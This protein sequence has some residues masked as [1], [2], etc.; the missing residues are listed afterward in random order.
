VEAKIIALVN[1]KRRIGK[2]TVS[3]NLAG[4]LARRGKGMSVTDADPQGFEA[5]I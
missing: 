2:T 5:N 4:A 3:M 1:Q